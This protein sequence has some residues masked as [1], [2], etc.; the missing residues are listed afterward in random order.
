MLSK[1][2]AI[3]L[4][5]PLLAGGLSG[6]VKL[7]DKN[8]KARESLKDVIAILEPLAAPRPALGKRPLLRIRTVGKRFA[9]RVAWTTPSSLCT[10]SN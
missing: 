2:V 6:P 1:L 10:F 9:P 3:A 5:T 7:M 8:G 4:T